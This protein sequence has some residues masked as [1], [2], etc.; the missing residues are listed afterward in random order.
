MELILVRGLPGS[1]KTTIAR[2]FAEIGYEHYEADDYFMYYG[3]YLFDPKR[4][5][6]AHATC[7]R[8]TLYAIQEKVPCVVANTFSQI[9]EMEPYIDA[10]L[11]AGFKI[12][13]IEARGK[14]ESVHKVPAH[15]IERMADRWQ[16]LD[17]R[18]HQMGGEEANEFLYKVGYPELMP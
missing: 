11:A 17:D 15:T 8:D 18:F 10:A 5:P 9:W 2:E 12:T 14:W 3:E 4:L 7:L 1:G 16:E 13:V 6:V